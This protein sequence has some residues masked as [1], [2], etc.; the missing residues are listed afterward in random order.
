MI[1][2]ERQ[3]KS[4]LVYWK[5][6]YVVFW[7]NYGFVLFIVLFFFIDTDKKMWVIGFILFFVDRGGYVF[8]S[9]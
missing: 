1:N 4:Y 7:I 8:V 9:L 6:K 3:G 2:E 5:I